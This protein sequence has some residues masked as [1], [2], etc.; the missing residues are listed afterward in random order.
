MMYP[1]FETLSLLVSQA[2]DFQL[3]N[4]GR[5]EKNGW[6]LCCSVPLFLQ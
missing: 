1:E 3:E 2:I 4:F 5:S 6:E